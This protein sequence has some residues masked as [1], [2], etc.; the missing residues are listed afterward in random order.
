M[1]VFSLTRWSPFEEL[2]NLHR[3]MDHAF[4]RHR[5]ESLF[6]TT[7]GTWVPATEI[8]SGKDGWQVK[9]ELP[10]IDP[11]DICIDLHGNALTVKGERRRKEEKT[12]PCTSELSYGGFERTFTLPLKVDADKVAASYNNGML[13]LTL[14]LAESAKPHRIEI[15]GGTGS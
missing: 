12:E 7:A 3:D 5:G 14:P 9:M 2:H 6:R 8:I 13:E 10:G 1:N 11:Q 4:G 15:G